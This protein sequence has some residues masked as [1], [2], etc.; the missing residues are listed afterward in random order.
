MKLPVVA[1]LTLAVVAVIFWQHQQNERLTAEIAALRG[2]IAEAAK[3]REQDA[4]SINRLKNSLRAEAERT[5]AE[6]TELM[7]LRAQATRLRQS[8]Q[9]NAQL[10]T[11]RDRL[12]KNTGLSAVGET[13]EADDQSTP[14]QQLVHKKVVFA[15][16]LGTA[17]RMIAFENDEH[18]PAKLPQVVEFMLGLAS[19]DIVSAEQFELVYKGSLRDV[20][21]LENLIVAREKEPVQL[22]NGQW[23]KAYAFAIGAS[24]TISAATRDG[25]AAKEKE[26]GLRESNP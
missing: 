1:A 11:E 20:K 6:R 14:E 18:L 25:F 26:L 23:V 4:Q 12:A 7:R 5:Q 10:K 13:K 16:H 19:P 17:L 2:Q 21:D 24:A 3:L 9:E 8:E 22:A 15:K